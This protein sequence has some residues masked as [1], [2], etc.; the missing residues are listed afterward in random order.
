M[1]CGFNLPPAAGTDLPNFPA[2][3][4]WQPILGSMQ[5]YAR[6][7]GHSD[8][9]SWKR[10]V[11]ADQVYVT[12]GP[13]LS[14]NVNGVGPGG[15]VQLPASGAEVTITAEIA[16][17]IGLR[18]FELIRMGDAIGGDVLKTTVGRVVLWRIHKRLQVQKSCWLYAVKACRSTPYERRCGRKNHGSSPTQ[19]PIQR[20]FELLSVISQFGR[21]K[22]QII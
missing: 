13:V 17:P 19:S 3:D 11:A 22:M 8:F 7:N 6:T 9:E 12:S 1:N 18:S 2:R 20:P 10:A 15:V 4:P 14:M 16:T 21:T 5:M